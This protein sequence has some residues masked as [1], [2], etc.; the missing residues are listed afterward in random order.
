MGPHSI[1]LTRG[2]IG[3]R[4]AGSSSRSLLAG[5]VGGAA[6]GT[7][8]K[9]LWIGVVALVAQR[10][11]VPQKAVS[12]RY[13]HASDAVCTFC[14]SRDGPDELSLTIGWVPG[15]GASQEVNNWRG[16]APMRRP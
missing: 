16:G 13:M 3:R 15:P 9:G 14:L 7:D 1:R 5:D 12:T 2:P 6:A 10:L 4:A 11:C 8:G